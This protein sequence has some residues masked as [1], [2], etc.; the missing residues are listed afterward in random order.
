MGIYAGY[1]ERVKA[2]IN[3][4]ANIFNETVAGT[5]AINADQNTSPIDTMTR[6]HQYAGYVRGNERITVSIELY[7]RYDQLPVDFTT[8]DYDLNQLSLVLLVPSGNW[9]LD[10]DVFNN[11]KWL[12][13]LQ[14]L[15]LSSNDVMTVSTGNAARTGLQFYATTFAYRNILT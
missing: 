2:F 3:G 15:V 5:F 12:L 11:S 1:F 7:M 4:D 8:L 6:N 14:G 9:S 13:E 10:Q